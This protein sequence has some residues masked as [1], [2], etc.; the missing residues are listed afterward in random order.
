MMVKGK[1]HRATHAAS[2]KIKEMEAKEVSNEKQ[3]HRNASKT[4]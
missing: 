1:G 4:A 3:V 2:A